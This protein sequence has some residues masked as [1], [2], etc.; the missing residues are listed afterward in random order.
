MTFKE[1]SRSNTGQ[2]LIEGVCGLIVFLMVFVVLTAFGVNIYIYGAQAAKLQIVANETAK[3]INDLYYWYGAK[4]PQFQQLK[5]H[6]GSGTGESTGLAIGGGTHR[7][8]QSQFDAISYARALCDKLGLP[9]AALDVR[10][11]D[12]VDEGDFE[13]TK[14]EI[15]RNHLILPFG[16]NKVFPTLTTIKATGIAVQATSPPPGFIRF[17]YNLIHGDLVNPSDTTDVTQV[18]ILP[19]FGFQTDLKSGSGG[20]NVG[21]TDNNSNVV[22]SQPDDNLCTW[23][24]LN[25][26]TVKYPDGKIKVALFGSPPMKKNELGGQTWSFGGTPK[27]ILDPNH[28]LQ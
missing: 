19:S 9:S 3:R 8:S 21:G 15:T 22:G 12:T 6:D 25:V 17:G 16:L 28:K 18:S 27:E 24:G 23:N 11:S 26:D 14:V 5:A 1:R 4:R 2:S 7:I 13:Y 20:P 10:Y